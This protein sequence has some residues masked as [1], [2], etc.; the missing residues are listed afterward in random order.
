[1]NP[2]VLISTADALV[3]LVFALMVLRQYR[4]R[5]RPYQLLWAIAFLIWTVAVAAE[6]WVA[7]RGGWSQASYRTYYATGALLVPAVL[8]VGTLYLLAAGRLAT[9]GL[10]ALVVLGGL[11][12][13]LVWTVPLAQPG[14]LAVSPSEIPTRAFPFFPVRLIIVL[15]N[16]AGSV[17]FIGGALY[18]W[19][20]MRGRPELR[21]RALGVSLI[22][23]GGIVAAAAHSLGALGL[24][25][26]FR[27]SELVAVLLI[28]AGFLQASRVA[29]PIVGRQAAGAE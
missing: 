8:G 13:V 7:L 12:F 1:M 28:F 11:G 2:N 26:L 5:R 6:G 23:L 17:A 25:D 20:Q 4:E 21:H 29:Q 3:G 14:A 10:G 27:L 18:S 16:I 9:W 19:W 24:L 22:A 15:L